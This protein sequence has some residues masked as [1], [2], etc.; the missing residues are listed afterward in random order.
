M[1]RV[2]NF[3]LSDE[4]IKRNKNVKD[5]YNKILLDFLNNNDTDFSDFDLQLICKT[6]FI[7]SNKYVNYSNNIIFKNNDDKQVLFNLIYNNTIDN[8]VNYLDKDNNYYIDKIN[9]MKKHEKN[10]INYEIVDAIMNDKYEELVKYKEY[11]NKL[12]YIFLYY[13]GIQR[14]LIEFLQNKNNITTF[15]EFSD[16]KLGMISD[17]F[18]RYNVHYMYHAINMNRFENYHRY[19]DNFQN[20]YNNRA[21]YQ[22]T[23]EP[24]FITKDNKITTNKSE[25]SDRNFTTFDF[26]IFLNLPEDFIDKSL[27]VGNKND[28]I[29]NKS[30]Y[31]YGQFILNENKE[32]H[33]IPHN[34]QERLYGLGNIALNLKEMLYMFDLMAYCL[35]LLD[36][37]KAFD[38]I[39]KKMQLV[40]KKIITICLFYYLYI[41]LM[42]YKEGNAFCAEVA[43]HS[44]LKKYV[45]ADLVI[46]MN[47]N[48]ILDVEALLLPFISFYNNCFQS[49]GTKYT[50]YFVLNK[51]E[52]SSTANAPSTDKPVANDTM[53]VNNVI[54]KKI[55][56]TWATNILPPK[57]QESFNR[58]CADNH[59]FDC[60]L[61]TDT[62]CY[63]FIKNNFSASILKTYEKII[64]GAYKADLWRYCVLYIYGG[65]YLDIKFCT[66]NNFKLK[67]LL[68]KEYFVLDKYLDTIKQQYIY[69]GFII[70]KPR[71]QKLAKCINQIVKNVKNNYYGENCLSPTGPGLLDSCF[72]AAEK[73]ELEL[74]LSCTPNPLISYDNTNILYKNN[75]IL[76]TYN[77]YRLEQSANMKTEH[78]GSAWGKRNI[79]NND[80]TIVEPLKT[81]IQEQP[82]NNKITKK[83]LVRGWRNINHSYSLINQFQLLELVK[84]KELGLYHEDLPYFVDFW[85][86]TTNNSG[87]DNTSKNTINNISTY[88]NEKVDTILN[89]TTK[90]KLSNNYSKNINFIVLEFGLEKTSIGD[91]KPEDFTKDNNYVITPST[92]CKN[93]LIESGLDDN[94]IYIIPH[95]VDTNIFKPLSTNIKANV[96]NKLNIPKDDYVFLNIGGPFHNKGL[97]ILLN[98]F[99]KVLLLN[100][101]CKLILKYNEDLYR[102]SLNN[103]ISS[104]IKDDQLRKKIIDNTIIINKTLTL[105]EL[106]EL[107]NSVD[108]Y[109]SSYRGEGFNIPVL[110]AIATGLNVLVT[111]GGSTDDFILPEQTTKI[112]AERKLLDNNDA[113]SYYLEPILDDLVIKMLYKSKEKQTLNTDILNKHMKKY[114]WESVVKQLMEVL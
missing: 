97:D 60:K 61:Y 5:K 35:Y 6:L 69:N 104:I 92:W 79:Y 81:V 56:T 55:F 95:G 83:L 107:Y 14:R 91:N 1:I 75:I 27:F 74:K 76:T 38:N 101:N 26:K 12:V 20:V 106:N 29:N 42:P 44:L 50:P 32:I 10:T 25:K 80:P 78:Y 86:A 109:V 16:L 100:N 49:D 36:N 30:I 99:G 2:N 72:T 54:P 84:Q 88:N 19:K 62:D 40:E 63:N 113:V 57:M 110:E 96:R 102:I 114:S 70:A 87:L 34:N 66:E 77:E 51:K 52:H 98:A 48:I 53:V 47:S 68:N 93:K 33:I 3:N 21:Q 108:L 11:Y 31:L 67:N 22:C 13:T 111:E 46:S 4:D 7:K 15:K 105:S 90:Y 58:L 94:K 103:Y 82:I 28:Y 89:I 17:M 65:V 39:L 43:F 41:L 18:I 73:A 37:P 23:E 24:I 112:R 59:E 8:I 64:P 85:S 9:F 45:N 71:N